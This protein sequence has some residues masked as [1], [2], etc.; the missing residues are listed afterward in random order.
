MALVVLLR[1]IN[2]GGHR[3]FR[4]TALAGELQHL[5]A[6]N[7]GATGVLVIR[8]RVSRVQLR[9]EIARR[10]PFQAHIMICEGREIIRLQSQNFFAGYRSGPDVV[11]FVSL[12]SRRPGPVPRLPVSLPSARNWL[13]R[14]VAHDGR[15]LVGLY[16]RQMR[17]IS[18]LGSLDRVFGVPLTTRNWNTITSIAKALTVG[19][20][21]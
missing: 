3:S 8:Q 10:L 21:S 13:V 17:V 14:V 9:A 2:V 18:C 4:P 16:R 12:M 5:G 1:G 20:A 7:I 15:F 11:R 6:V 19:G